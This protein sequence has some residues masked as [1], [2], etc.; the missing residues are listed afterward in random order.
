MMGHGV[1]ISP[2]YDKDNIDDGTLKKIMFERKTTSTKPCPVQ[3]DVR[4]LPLAFA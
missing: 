3:R 2:S 4:T 1:F